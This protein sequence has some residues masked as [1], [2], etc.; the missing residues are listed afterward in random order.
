MLEATSALGG[1]V[2]NGCTFLGSSRCMAVCTAV[3][4]IDL[5]CDHR[6]IIFSETKIK[7]EGGNLGR[8]CLRRERRLVE[9]CCECVDVRRG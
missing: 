4:A 9:A 7:S 3:R 2:K 1:L 5:G 8:V 6:R